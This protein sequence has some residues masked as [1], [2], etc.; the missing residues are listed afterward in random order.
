MLFFRPTELRKKDLSDP[1]SLSSFD[2]EQRYPPPSRCTTSS[3][4]NQY[5]HLPN[6]TSIGHTRRLHQHLP[7][8]FTCLSS[9][10]STV[11][12]ALQGK[13]PGPILPSAQPTFIV[14]SITYYSPNSIHTEYS[15]SL[16]VPP[17][18]PL[19][20]HQPGGENYLSTNNPITGPQS[21]PQHIHQRARTAPFDHS[22]RP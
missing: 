11:T 18:P 10:D 22:H 12:G 7:S 19:L 6:T 13:L 15:T 5:S 4:Y 16:V 14:G 17:P 9:L 3:T 20:A 8:L 21:C 1:I 2:R